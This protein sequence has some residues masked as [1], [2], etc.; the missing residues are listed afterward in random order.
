MIL[1]S[2]T[3]YKSL[4]EEEKKEKEDLQSEVLK[5]QLQLL[6]FSRMIFGSKSEAFKVN[7]AQ[8]TL[9][10]Q[11]EQIPAVCDLS[12]AKRVEGYVKGNPA[13]TR[14]LS[15]FGSYLD[16][17]PHFYETREPENL[18]EGAEK[19]GEDEHKILEYT[20]GKL[21]VRVIV[22]PK[23][24]LP[25]KNGDD[26][27][28]IIAVEA[29]S[30][31]L[32]KC[33]AGASTLAQILVDKYTDHL[34]VFRQ[35]ARFARDGTIIPYNT[36][37]DWTGKTID[38]L[39]ILYPVLK[40]AILSTRYIHVDETG[41]K[42]LCSGENK[43]HRKIHDGYLWCYNNSIEKM[44][45]FDYQHGRGEK[46]AEG[47][48]KDFRGIIQTD[49]WQVY[50]GIAS[51]QEDIKQICCL[52][53]ARR[54][55]DEALSTDKELAGYALAKFQAIYE[56]ER[57]CKDNNLSYEEIKDTRQARSAPLLN[58]LH[59]WMTEQYKTLPS[60]PI[61]TAIG[62]AMRHWERLC[63]YTKDGMLKPDNNPVENAI[64][65]T[66]LGRKNFLFAGSQRGAERIAII[67]SLLGTCKLNN[68]NPYLWL[69]DVLSRINDHPI[70]K[71]SELLPHNWIKNQPTQV[72]TL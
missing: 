3:D 20:P 44:V 51:K 64:R 56:V 13:K 34:P 40:K 43:R 63:Y 62:Y 41:L 68:I 14:D 10:I 55:F 24:K 19:I 42:V 15:E 58:E 9:A 72:A 17:L 45:F 2:T 38:L 7:P 61:S 18:P 70:N 71:I 12:S 23:Y 66:V 29:P 54:K 32:R 21:F 26:T 36:L 16:S 27:V 11:A 48:L 33:I 60:A 37:L 52:A 22:I 4:Y 69:K 25:A 1:S 8:L 53:H 67:Y 31:P 46:Y 5:M 28:K 57:Y 65:P 59:E 50:Q 39:E 47:I 49:G 30:R 35:K 6:K